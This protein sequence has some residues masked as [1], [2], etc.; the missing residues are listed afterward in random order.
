VF[1]EETGSDQNRKNLAIFIARGRATH[2]DVKLGF[3]LQLLHHLFLFIGEPTILGA[4]G[5]LQEQ[6]GCRMGTTT[7]QHANREKC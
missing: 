1:P 4:V 6:H 7:K 5:A 3:E 2:L